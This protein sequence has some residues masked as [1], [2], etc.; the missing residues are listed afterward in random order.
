MILEILLSAS[1][2]IGVI[3]TMTAG[4][5]AFMEDPTPLN[6]LIIGLSFFVLAQVL[7]GI[8]SHVKNNKDKASMSE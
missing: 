8:Q 2:A 3:Y 6:H 5:A 4:W 1:V 7:S